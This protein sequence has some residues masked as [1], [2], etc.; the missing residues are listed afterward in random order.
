MFVA[1]RDAL[2]K[3]DEALARVIGLAVVDTH[4]GV[5]IRVVDHQRLFE[6]VQDYA[7]AHGLEQILLQASAT[8]SEASGT[9][10]ETSLPSP[11][12]AAHEQ[13][14]EAAPIAPPGRSPPH[15]A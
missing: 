2:N 13:R 3:R 4:D 7:A 11:S 9:T 15:P 5:D 8:W 6:A 1:H 12:P 10:E 14:T